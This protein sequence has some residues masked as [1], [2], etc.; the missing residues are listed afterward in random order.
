MVGALVSLLALGMGAE[1]KTRCCPGC[2]EV[3]ARAEGSLTYLPGHCVL[4]RCSLMLAYPSLAG[5][6]AAGS[7]N[8]VPS[9]RLLLPCQP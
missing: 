1:M 4:R 5:G 8:L 7:L 9:P 6:G 3:E 2:Q